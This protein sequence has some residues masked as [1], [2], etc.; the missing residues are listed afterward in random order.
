MTD[1]RR[2]MWVNCKQCEHVWVALRLPMEMSKAAK[3]MVKLRCPNCAA[4]AKKIRVGKGESD[5]V[6]TPTN[7]DERGC[8]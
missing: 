3:I 5:A 1:D 8:S 7:S 2:A 4:D 6:D